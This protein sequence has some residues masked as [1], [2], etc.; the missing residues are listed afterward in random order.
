[1]ARFVEDD[2]DDVDRLVM[3][4]VCGFV[5]IAN[6]FTWDEKAKTR[7]TMDF[8]WNI[9]LENI[10]RMLEVKKDCEKCMAMPVSWVCVDSKIEYEDL[11]L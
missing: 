9:L 8:L 6:A 11:L 7:A 3:N 4:G 10:D 2:D 1:M 5:G